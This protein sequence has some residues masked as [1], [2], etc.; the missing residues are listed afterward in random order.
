[1]H[2][3]ELHRLQI[4]AVDGIEDA[5]GFAEATQLR[6]Q[7]TLRRPGSRVRITA[8]CSAQARETR[9]VRERRVVRP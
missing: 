1:M 5:R 9:R 8:P 7:A 2:E 6:S 3:S 4:H